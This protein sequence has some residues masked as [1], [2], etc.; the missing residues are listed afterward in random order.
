VKTKLAAAAVA[1][2][3]LTAPLAQADEIIVG[4]TRVPWIESAGPVTYAPCGPQEICVD[5]PASMWPVTDLSAPT[6]GESTAAGVESLDEVLKGSS[7]DRTRAYSQGALVVDGWLVEHADDPDAPEQMTFVVFGDAIR[8]NGTGSGGLFSYMPAGGYIPLMDYTVPTI[9]DTKYHVVVVAN[10]Y[11]M[12]ADWPD[13]PWNLLADL[14]S[15]ISFFAGAHYY[16]VLPTSEPTRLETNALGGTTTTYFVP[17]EKLYLTAPLWQRGIDTALLDAV[18][19]PLVDM[20]FSRNDPEF[21]PDAV[22]E[23]TSLPTGDEYPPLTSISED[24]WSSGET[25][26]ALTAASAALVWSTTPPSWAGAL[27]VGI[28]LFLS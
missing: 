16:P 6:L 7:A 17:S 22:S 3:V 13:R 10:E 24:S 14:N 2:T 9:P 18:L 25:L 4:G 11:D 21:I 5:Y 23:W 28:A 19:R 12:A 15:L 26:S 1:A 27:V 20:G 8:S